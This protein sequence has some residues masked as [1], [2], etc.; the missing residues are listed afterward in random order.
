MKTIPL[1][2][3]REHLSS[4]GRLITREEYD[5]I[6]SEVSTLEAGLKDAETPVPIEERL[7]K[8][9]FCMLIL[10]GFVL[11]FIALSRTG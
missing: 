7:R 10:V 5:V 11:I 4:P 9:E 2:S 6:M 3:G 1:H 8:L